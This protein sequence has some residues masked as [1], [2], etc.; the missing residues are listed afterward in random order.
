MEGRREQ[1]AGG[2]DQHHAAQDRIHD[3]EDAA[4]IVELRLHRPHPREQQRGLVDRRQPRETRDQVIA[5]RTQHE[6][7][8]EQRHREQRPPDMRRQKRSMGASC[9][10]RR[11]GGSWNARSDHRV[12]LDLHQD[13][14]R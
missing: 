13:P 10:R 1:E 14:G 8:G 12:R 3:L 9:A 11:S 7:D 4:G 5:N 2:E 6:R